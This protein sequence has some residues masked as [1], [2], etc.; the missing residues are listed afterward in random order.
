MGSRVRRSVAGEAHENGDIEQRHHRFKNAVEQALM[1]RG[2]RDFASRVDYEAVS[3]D[4]VQTAQR[5]S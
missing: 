5:R 1:L 2:S 3:E 4:P